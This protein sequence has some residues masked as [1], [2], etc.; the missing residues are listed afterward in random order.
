[1][2]AIRKTEIE[3]FV[4]LQA[5]VGAD[6]RGSFVKIF[7]EEFFATHGL[8][9]NFA[10]QYYSR[11]KRGV[12]RG[13][14]FQLP[15]H[16]HAKMVYCVAG[17]IMDVAVDL[18]IDSPTFGRHAAM[19]LSAGCA[20]QALLVSGL[21]HGFYVLSEMAIVVYNVTTTYAPD[22]DTGIRWDSA[23][24]PWPDAHPLLSPRDA[25]L[26][27]LSDFRSPFRLAGSG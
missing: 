14:H 2:F 1:M 26:P 20:N 6:D 22:Y 19:T 5:S 7:H 27:R 11:S 8:P 10:E 12:L 16:D 17:E 13:L 3:G 18:R 24:V 25:A 15:P 21:A 23:G 9:I 4:E